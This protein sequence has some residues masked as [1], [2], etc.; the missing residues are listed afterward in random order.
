MWIVQT[1]TSSFD[2]HGDGSAWIRPWPDSK[3]S[4][5]NLGIPSSPVILR[6]FRFGNFKLAIN[7]FEIQLGELANPDKAWTLFFFSVMS[8]LK[9]KRKWNFVSPRHSSVKWRDHFISLWQNVEHPA[10]YPECIFCSW[11]CF[12]CEFHNQRWLQMCHGYV[13]YTQIYIFNHF[14]GYYVV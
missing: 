7:I 8:N 12:D 13:L 14:D 11:G 5:S 6:L 3:W 1:F 4:Y 2:C 9:G 10:V